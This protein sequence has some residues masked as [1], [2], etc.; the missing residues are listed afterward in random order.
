MGAAVTRTPP[1]PRWRARALCALIATVLVCVLAD[2]AQAEPYALVVSGAT[3]GATAGEQIDQWRS[4]LVQ[5]LQGSLRYPADHVIVLAEDAGAGALPATKAQVQTTFTA[6]RARLTARDQLLVV[7]LGHGSGGE[8]EDARFNLVG[9]DMTAR[10]WAAQLAPLQASLVLVNTTGGSAPF[11]P[12]L[13]GRRRVVLTATDAAAQQYDTIF[14]QFFIEALRGAADTDK[15]GKVSVWE[16]F[17]F[18]SAGVRGWYEQRGRLVT[19]TAML[20][21]TG[22]GVGRGAEEPGDDGVLAQLT[23]VQTDAPITEPDPAK[24]A[25]LVRRAA[26]MTEFEALRLKKPSMDAETYESALERVLLEIAQIDRA[27]RAVAH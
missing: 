24:R 26:L 25:A 4:A 15:N 22:D 11:L 12:A 8:G 6:L 13:S 5:L 3:G 7:W 10:E 14:P 20:D 2:R 21:D 1:R 9:P 19:E 18:A 23:Y 16:A 17:T 27:M